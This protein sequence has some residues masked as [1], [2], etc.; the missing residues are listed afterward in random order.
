MFTRSVQRRYEDP[1]DVLWVATLARVGIRLR[2]DTEVFAATDG[3]GSL[4]LGAPSTLDA[5][6]CLAQMIFHE[7]CH[8][9]VAGPE[10]L[11]EPDWG[12]SNTDA[13]DLVQEHACLRLQAALSAPLGLREVLAPTTDFRSFYDALPSDPLQGEAEDVVRA[14]AACT[15]MRDAPWHPHV[16]NALGATAALIAVVAPY[17]NSDSLF[18]TFRSGDDEAVDDHR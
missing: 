14:R 12:M 9:L 3:R 4:T 11:S 6:D 8:S 1:L 2:R 17:A 13:R 7:L 10:G 16:Q 18:A 15:R 5:D